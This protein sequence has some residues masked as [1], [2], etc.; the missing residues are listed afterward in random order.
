MSRAT[1]LLTKDD[2]RFWLVAFD[3]PTVS[4]ISASAARALSAP[5][6]KVETLA[7]ANECSTAAAFPMHVAQQP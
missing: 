3:T 4:E 5:V 6:T 2:G 7:A 1:V